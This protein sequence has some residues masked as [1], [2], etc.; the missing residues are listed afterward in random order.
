MGPS[1]ISTHCL[2]FRCYATTES[3]HIGGT[4]RR[5]QVSPVVDGSDESQRKS[6][7]DDFQMELEGLFS[8]VKSMITDGNKGDAIDLLEANY[9]AVKEQMVAGSKTVEEAAI[10][11]VI[12]LGYM[13]IGDFKMVESILN[14]LNEIVHDL[15]DDEPFL[16]AIL[17]HMGSMHS[18]L[19]RYEKSILSYKRVLETL[20]RNHGSNSTLLVMP[21]LGM[22]KA[23]GCAGRATKAID[24]YHRVISILESSSGVESKELVIPLNAL[25]NLLIEEG[26]AKDAESAFL[27]I[28]GIYTK[29]YGED[30]ERVAMAMC[31][32][33]NAKCA[34]GDAEEAIK[35]YRNALQVLEHSEGMNLDDGILEKTRIELAELLHVVGRE[36]EGRKLLEECLSITRKYKGE[37]DPN[38]VTHLTNLATSYSRSKNYVESERLLRSSLQI[39]KK[40]VGPDDP[41]I[42]FVML[43]LAVNLYNLKQDEEA[44]QLALEVLRVREK[45]FGNDSVPVGEALE[46]LICIQNRMERDDGEI[47][48]LLKRNL[49]IQEKTFGHESE[50]V[51]ET[52]KKIVF[53]MDKM[54]IKDQKFPFQRRLTSLRNKFKQQVQY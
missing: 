28:L 49:N 12:A 10:L 20:E 51:V 13:A 24:I 6:L 34:K 43:Q 42:T 21:L 32:L 4:N 54:G 23:L 15:S 53:Y 18:A 37:E 1:G 5:Y 9:E 46:C 52:L 25:G 29:L 31:S 45:A 33:A 19:G 36:N 14:M 17:T 16:D 7:G 44:E 30:D 39:M 11:D 3:L 22:G 8:E 38:F 26:K 2:V 40:T 27:R 35:L 50:Q 48:K 41:S 47:L